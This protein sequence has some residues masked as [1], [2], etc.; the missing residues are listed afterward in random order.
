MATELKNLDLRELG[1]RLKQA[2]A[3]LLDLR[4]KKRLGTS[5]RPHLLQALR[6]GIARLETFA[7]LKE[8][9]MQGVSG[10]AFGFRRKRPA[11]G[12]PRR[13]PRRGLRRKGS[14]KTDARGEGR[15]RRLGM[16]KEGVRT[17]G[18]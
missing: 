16:H 1:E 2:R 4:L 18:H 10:A 9:E 5:G 17:E 15:S 7:R 11:G 3:E 6:K 14:P 12:G 13:S 8:L